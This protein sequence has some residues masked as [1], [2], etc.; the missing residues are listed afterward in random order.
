MTQR[1][2]IVFLLPLVLLLSGCSIPGLGGNTTAPPPI[3]TGV[4][5][6]I[7]RGETWIPKNAILS[8]NGTTPNLN[9]SNPQVLVMDPTDRQ[10]LY[11]GSVG[12]GLFYSYDGAES[13]WPSGPIRQGTINAIAVPN[14]EELHCNVYLATGNRILKTTDCG[15]FWEQTYYDT[16][17]KEQ[18]L[19][20]TIHRDDPRVLYAG[21][22]TGD[23]LRSL[24]SGKSWETVQ[25]LKGKITRLITH[26]LKTDILYAVLEKRGIWKTVDGGLTWNDLTE[27]LKSFKG[28]SDIKE[29]VIDPTRPDTVIMAT[30]YGLIRTTDGGA[31][32]AAIPLLTPPGKAPISA[33]S[34]NPANPVELYYTTD[35]TFYRS[36]DAGETWET[37]AL[38]VQGG[39]T[40]L[41]PDPKLTDVLYLGINK[42]QQQQQSGLGF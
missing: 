4:Y 25:R 32:W 7:D 15:R 26:P 40:I 35:T 33:L 5:K 22:S 17:L 20:L 37:R 2:A 28:G 11:F 9:F 12:Q 18:V 1:R 34:L 24:D 41:V 42:P 8:T 6:T 39:K 14:Q 36:S 13:W 19:S 30:T 10:T 23:V 16:R 3:A 38:P 21:L 31:N 27:G 29:L